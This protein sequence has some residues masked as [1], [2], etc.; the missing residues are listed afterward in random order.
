MHMAR[1][2]RAWKTAAVFA[3]C[4]LG[5]CLG[6]QTGQPSSAQ[7]PTP[8][9]FIPADEAVEGVS[10]AQFA[11]AF[12]GQ[13]SAPLRWSTSAGVAD[14]AAS[15]SGDE[16]TISISYDGA[17]ARQAPCS[18]LIS[19]PVHVTV[20]T[21]GGSVSEEGDV[22]LTGVV[23]SVASASFSLSAQN[24][25]VAASLSHVPATAELTGTLTPTAA[26]VGADSAEFSSDFSGTGADG[27][28]P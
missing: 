11:Q 15:L 25:I 20:T 12:V 24:F 19:V 5:G 6:G 10:P 23:G 3:A 21:R 4:L 26:N 27:G 22:D 16:I 1:L 13:H 7:C 2:S 17:N 18:T 9:T 8:E 14:D 28:T